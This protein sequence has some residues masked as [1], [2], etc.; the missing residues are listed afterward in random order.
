ME[1]IDEVVTVSPK[2]QVVIPKK[3]RIAANVVKGEKMKI[4]VEK[5]KVIFEAIPPFESLI[6]IAAG[7]KDSGPSI[8]QL[9][10][11]A[12]ARLSRL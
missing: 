9:R 2:Y 8:K 12:D 1:S 4:S 11:E 3:A 10:R 5:N 7:L 6:G